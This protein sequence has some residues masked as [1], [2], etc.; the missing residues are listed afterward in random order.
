MNHLEINHQ[1]DNLDRAINYLNSNLYDAG[2]EDEI[3][4]SVSDF[5]LAKHLGI[6]SLEEGEITKKSWFNKVWMKLAEIGDAIG[7]FMSRNLASLKD[8]FRRSFKRMG[9]GEVLELRPD[10]WT[11]FDVK[12]Y[13]VNLQSRY[14]EGYFKKTTLSTFLSNPM[15]MLN[16]GFNSSSLC[17][18]DSVYVIDYADNTIDVNK[19]GVP[20]E[21]V[22]E[23]DVSE[24]RRTIAEAQRFSDSYYTAADTLM[25]S[26]KNYKRSLRGKDL[27]FEKANTMEELGRNI[28]LTFRFWEMTTSAYIAYVSDLQNTILSNLPPAN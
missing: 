27:P 6:E 21:D 26:Y 10:A 19:H 3:G 13:P 18:G 12:D 4:S 28:L 16:G 7:D 17:V 24:V 20:K 11:T 9:L 14:A 8:F 2:L 23:K 15:E 22:R 5:L 1:L 25:N